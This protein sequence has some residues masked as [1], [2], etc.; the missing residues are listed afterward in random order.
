MPCSG[1]CLGALDHVDRD[2]GVD[3]VGD[4]R[5][6]R[7]RA[8]RRAR[9]RGTA[10]ATTDQRRRDTRRHGSPLGATSAD[11]ADR[12]RD[13]E[14]ALAGRPPAHPSP[15]STV[16]AARS[17]ATSVAEHRGQ[18]ARRPAATTQQTSTGIRVGARQQREQREHGEHDA[19]ATT[20]AP[21]PPSRPAQQVESVGDRRRQPADVE[22]QALGRA[23]AGSP[24][25][26]TARAARAPRR[27]AVAGG[28]QTERSRIAPRTTRTRRPRRP[29]GRGRRASS[30][31]TGANAAARASSSPARQ[32]ARQR[33]SASGSAKPS[34]AWA[35]QGSSRG[36]DD[37]ARAG[38]RPRR[39][40]TTGTSAQ[41]VAPHSSSHR[42]APVE[43]TSRPTTRRNRQAPH[44]ANGTR[45][46]QER[47]RPRPTGC[48]RAAVASSA[49]GRTYGGAGTARA[50]AQRVPG[51]DLQAPPVAGA[52]RDR[53]QPAAGDR[54]ERRARAPTSATTTTT[55]RS[56]SATGLVRNRATQPG[57]GDRRPRRPSAARAGRSSA[58][59]ALGG[60]GAP[61]LGDVRGLVGGGG[62]QVADEVEPVPVGHPPRRQ[63]RS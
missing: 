39:P 8:T 37:A 55:G 25:S 6:R 51:L 28:P 53:R 17:R 13:D 15:A 24:G 2:V 41:V 30:H 19:R 9:R 23:R 62:R 52:V 29:R 49:S 26:T 10:A 35:S 50:D 36:D 11:G 45:E 46:Q 63:Q 32:A 1:P 16:V 60:R 58:R 4:A 7:T 47:P 38:R 33:R 21:S 27:R 56:T 22:E 40:Q 44:S 43:T 54:A 57:V 5:R 12:R 31:S 34:A 61:P 3:A 20:G 42:G 59:V 18:H 48:R 14:R